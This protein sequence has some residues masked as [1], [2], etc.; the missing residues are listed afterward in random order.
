MDLSD[1]KQETT[2]YLTFIKEKMI[3]PSSIQTTNN[4]VYNLG[5]SLLKTIS[6]KEL[7][8][9]KNLVS[10][11]QTASHHAKQ[12]QRLVL[13]FFALA[14]L[15]S[16]YLFYA[17]YEATMKSVQNVKKASYN[18]ANG[19][20]SQQIPVTTNDE[21]G[22]ICTAIN[23]MGIIF[24]SIIKETQNTVMEVTSQASVIDSLSKEAD[25]DMLTQQSQLDMAASA[26][27]EMSCSA[28]EV[29]GSTENTSH[30]AGSAEQQAFNADQVA[31]EAVGEID[32]LV[33]QIEQTSTAINK[34][35]DD[36]NNIGTVTDVIRG[37]AEQTNLLALNAAIEAARAGEQGRGFAVVADEVR[38]LAQR[39]RESTDEIQS[40]ISK[41]QAASSKVVDIIQHSKTSV[42]Q[43]S[44]KVSQTLDALNVINGAVGEINMMSSQIASAA[45]QQATSSETLS[46]NIA[47]THQLSSKAVKLTSEIS[48]AS[49]DLNAAS[50]KLYNKLMNYKTA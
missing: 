9:Q 22:E 1:L 11:I 24:S 4:E 8:I 31:R 2:K 43:S 12:T 33:Q 15:L 29:R 13:S 19:D 3:E 20:L 45:T 28:Q 41:L 5:A 35:A 27:T 32:T 16:G 37:I 18:M 38:T 10:D 49:G 17:F 48:K 40:M 36:A 25:Q 30:S 44:E 23:N 21:L 26:M 7:L 6:A 50:E 39:T 34:L 46:N 14:T 42:E 47:E